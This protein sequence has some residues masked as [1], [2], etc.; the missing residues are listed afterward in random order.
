V[1]EADGGGRGSRGRE[2]RSSMWY[3]PD[4]V[5]AA[6]AYSVQARLLDRRQQA[7]RDN[8]AVGSSEAPRERH[9]VAVW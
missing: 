7:A 2:E 1:D 6:A 5:D 9:R 4:G 3:R 8:T